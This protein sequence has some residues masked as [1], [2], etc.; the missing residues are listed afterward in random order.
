MWGYIA[1]STLK[2]TKLMTDV[3]YNEIH[4]FKKL[5]QIFE[6]I[7]EADLA[8][9]INKIKGISPERKAKLICMLLNYKSLDITTCLDIRLYALKTISPEKFQSLKPH[10]HCYSSNS[11]YEYDP[12]KNGQNIIKHGI[13]FGEVMSDFG[14]TVVESGKAA[15]K[16]IFISKMKTERLSFPLSTF[17]EIEF[18]YVAAAVLSYCY[19]VVAN[20]AA[21]NLQPGSCFN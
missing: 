7:S 15:Q 20:S 3:L 8:N 13:S 12:Q 17:Q 1:I 19:M 9:A 18:I 5:N 6:E 21:E 16:M 10:E 4:L 2:G 11:Q 14:S